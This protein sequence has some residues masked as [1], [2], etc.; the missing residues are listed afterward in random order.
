MYIKMYNFIFLLFN[1]LKVSTSDSSNSKFSEFSLE[2]LCRLAPLD[3]ES[4]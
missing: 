2:S 4:L 1:N 3:P